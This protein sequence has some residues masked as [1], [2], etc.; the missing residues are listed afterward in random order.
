VNAGIFLGGF[1]DCRLLERSGAYGV[2]CK[3]RKI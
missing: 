3:K 1:W 2:L